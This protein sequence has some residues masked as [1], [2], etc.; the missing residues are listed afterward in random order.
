LAKRIKLDTAPFQQLEQQL[1]TLE[2]FAKSAN[3]IFGRACRKIE[4]RV[5]KMLLDN[6]EATDLKMTTGELV[7]YVGECRVLPG[8]NGIRVAAPDGRGGSISFSQ[9][10]H[11]KA[12]AL[13]FGAVRGLRG[14]KSW[15]T[16]GK[17]K[18]ALQARGGESGLGATATKAHKFWE[19]SSAQVGQLQQWLQEAIQD[20]FERIGS[21]K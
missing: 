21:G 18:R 1:T 14:I 16:R 20:E 13:N 8:K 5:Q 6:L 2:K 9:K 15:R 12:A 11:I 10:D 7:K 3:T 19:L 17:I 4:G